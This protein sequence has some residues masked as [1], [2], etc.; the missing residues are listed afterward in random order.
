LTQFGWLKA[1]DNFI[2]GDTGVHQF[3]CDAAFGAIVLNPNLVVTN[4]DV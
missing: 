2:A 4:I 3:F 1:K